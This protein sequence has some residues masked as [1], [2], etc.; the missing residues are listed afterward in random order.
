MQNLGVMEKNDLEVK[1]NWIPELRASTDIICHIA[2]QVWGHALQPNTQNWDESPVSSLFY[3]L[4]FLSYLIPYHI[5]LNYF[6]GLLGKVSFYTVSLEA[7]PGL[8][9]L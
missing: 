8:T 7:G 4:N 3:L 5:K 9:M 6:L 1:G 2:R